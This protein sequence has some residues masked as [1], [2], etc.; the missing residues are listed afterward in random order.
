[1]DVLKYN[2]FLKIGIILFLILLLLIPT[3]MIRGLVRERE[4]RQNEA[5]I[6]V[7][8]KW[9]EPQTLTGP[10]ISIPFYR[11]TMEY[12]GDFQKEKLVKVIDYMHFL[13]EELKIN[14]MIE[15]EHRHRG[16]YEIV[17]YDSE[18]LLSGFFKNLDLKQF[19]VPESDILLDKAVLSLGIS[20]LTGIEEQ[21]SLQFNQETGLFDPGMIS[22]DIIYSG[23]NAPVVLCD[24]SC[25]Y[26]FL[27]ELKLKGSQML[28]FVP[29][30]KITDVNIESSWANPSFNGAFLPDTHHI[31]D[32]GFTAGWNILHLNRNFPQS[33]SGSQYSVDESGFG[34]YLILP[35]D[36]YQK[37]ERSIKYAI[38]FIV[39]TFLVFFFVEILAK[40]FIHPIQYTLVGIALIVFFSLL[41]SITEHLNFDS[42]YLIS[43]VSV[44]ALISAYIR[45]ILRSSRLTLLIG[46]ILTILYI[47][48]YIILQIQDYA[49]LTGSIGI[50]IIL[51][52]VMYFSR[53]ID[54]YNIRIDQSKDVEEA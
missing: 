47:F 44:L 28:Y 38:L 27:F 50:F 7:S 45:T 32:D 53:K 30:G 24:D 39:F 21:V 42:A 20:D 48:I 33:W 46:G 3:T 12:V 34:V 17:V 54:W 25:S 51:A 52:L 8:S 13:P 29:M 4:Q 31:T 5:I 23:I 1:M 35:V 40:K 22:N 37:I 36:K 14:G 43:T 16:I 49:L 2:I 10:F 18:I 6:E 41:L 9:G 15:P 26:E 19:N 11:Y